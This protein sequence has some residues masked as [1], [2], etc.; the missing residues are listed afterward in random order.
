MGSTLSWP[1]CWLYGLYFLP[2]THVNILM[3]A[4]PYCTHITYIRVR[5]N[6]EVKIQAMLSQKKFDS[7]L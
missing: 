2:L 5:M 3:S 1:K 4:D 7:I 6:D